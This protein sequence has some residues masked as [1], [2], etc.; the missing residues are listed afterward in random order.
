MAMLLNQESP[1]SYRFKDAIREMPTNALPEIE[2]IFEQASM[3]QLSTSE[4]SMYWEPC[5][6]PLLND[7]QF[8][9][10]QTLLEERTG[11]YINIY[12]RSLLESNLIIRMREIQCSDYDEY[13][14]KVSSK[15]SGIVEWSVL[16]DRIMV[17]ETRFYRN[18][19]S[20]SLF[21]NYLSEKLKGNILDKNTQP[22]N[23]WSVG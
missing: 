12:H 10:W 2:D 3:S 1:D 17:Q 5:P 7:S 6:S 23:I 13:Y 20:L 9:Q 8:L 16:L 21:S 11:M 14:K 15:P 18:S 4:P 22:F 19:E